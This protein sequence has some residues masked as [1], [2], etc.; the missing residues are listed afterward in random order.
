MNR[1]KTISD[2][3][4]TFSSTK[5]SISSTESEQNEI[6]AIITSYSLRQDKNKLFNKSYALYEMKLFTR[7]KTWLVH[8]RYSQF[9]DLRDQLISKKVKN[10]P[11]YTTKIEDILNEY[12]R[13]KIFKSNPF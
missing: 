10:L 3:S 5:D 11:L 8:K 2:L 12:D 7:Y 9:V 6:S 1:N 4:T 13:I